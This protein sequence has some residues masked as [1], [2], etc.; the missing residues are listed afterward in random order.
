[1]YSWVIDDSTNFPNQYLGAL[2]QPQ[3]LNCNK[4]VE[5]IGQLSVIH[6]FSI[7][8]VLFQ[9]KSRATQR[10]LVSKT[11]NLT[12]GLSSSAAVIIDE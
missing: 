4:C 6:R 11:V 1:M 10:Q 3:F 5:N 7:S 9:F 2:R 12:L 8:D